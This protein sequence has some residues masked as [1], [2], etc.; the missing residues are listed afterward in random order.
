M[1]KMRGEMVEPTQGQF[2]GKPF[3][4]CGQFPKRAG[5]QIPREGGRRLLERIKHAYSDLQSVH[6]H[7][8]TEI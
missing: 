3:W 7:I 8:Q 1:S 5:I 2:V 6:L 4:G